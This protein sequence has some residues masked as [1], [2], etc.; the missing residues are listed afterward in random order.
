M[1]PSKKE[2]SRFYLWNSWNFLFH[3]TLN[4][5]VDVSFGRIFLTPPFKNEKRG[6]NKSEPYISNCTQYRKGTNFGFFVG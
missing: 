2:R 4:I 5:I 3:M 6:T 1:S